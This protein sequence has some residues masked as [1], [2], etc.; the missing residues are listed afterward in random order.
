VTG[1]RRFRSGGAPRASGGLSATTPWFDGA[2]D[3][4]RVYSGVLP[5]AELAALTR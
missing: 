3:E 4:L 5:E 2:L 1:K